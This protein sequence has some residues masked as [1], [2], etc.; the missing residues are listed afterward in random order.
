VGGPPEISDAR[1]APSAPHSY[2]PASVGSLSR[3]SLNTRQEGRVRRRFGRFSLQ[4]AVVYAAMNAEFDRNRPPMFQR[5]VLRRTCNNWPKTGRERAGNVQLNPPKKRAKTAI[6]SAF[7]DYLKIRFPHGS[8]GSSPTGGTTC[9]ARHHSS[10]VKAPDNQHA[11]CFS[12]GR[13]PFARTSLLPG[14]LTFT[15]GPRRET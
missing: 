1:D 7:V 2:C 5:L 6:W 10:M 3:Q 15:F 11:F 8:V 14:A 4:H 13:S 9:S 12:V